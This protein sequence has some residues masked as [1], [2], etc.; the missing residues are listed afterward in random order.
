MKVSV[1][2]PLYNRADRICNLYSTVFNQTHKDVELIVVDDGSNDDPQKAISALPYDDRLIYISQEN[3]GA[4]SARNVGI[5][6]ATGD[7]V[8]M[9]DSDDEFHSDHIESSLQ[10]LKSSQENTFVYNQVNAIRGNGVSVLKPA[11]G[12]VSGENVSEYLICH[13]G[14]IQTSTLVAYRSDFLQVMYDNKLPAG[15][16]TD[17]AIRAASLGFNF[18]MKERA[19]VDWDD[20]FDPLR[21]SSTPY[22]ERRLK[23]LKSVR[24]ILTEKAFRADR[25]WHYA[26]ALYRKSTKGKICAIYYYVIALVTGSYSPRLSLEVLLQILLSKHRY[27][28][29][30][31]F[32]IKYGAK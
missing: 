24:P 10:V 9:L 30:A 23:W 22:P 16:D 29:L 25:G 8:A 4:N 28:V 19:T 17:F 32:F 7:V 21:I 26:K 6:A 3:T 5:L 2:V 27:H 31:D 13:K 20:E 12:I 1:V 14:F 15:Q 11:R 18:V